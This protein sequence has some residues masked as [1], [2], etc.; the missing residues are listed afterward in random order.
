MENYLNGINW[1]S[2]LKDCDIQDCY[3]Q[4]LDIYNSTCKAFIPIKGDRNAKDIPKWLTPNIKSLIREK[5]RL[6]I[7]TTFNHPS[8]ITN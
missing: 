5:L 4:F 1:E 3:N 6:W 7:S 8:V 2:K